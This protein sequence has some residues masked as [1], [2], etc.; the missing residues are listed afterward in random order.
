MRTPQRATL[1][2][3]VVA[4][5]AGIASF[6]AA[7]IYTQERATAIDDAAL[8]IAGNASPSIESLAAARAEMRRLESLILQQ[9]DAPL[10]HDRFSEIAVSRKLLT[11][12]LQRY[13]GLPVFPGEREL[14]KGIRQSVRRF[15]DEIDRAL[16]RMAAKDKSG[17]R[18][19]AHGELRV[20]ADHA[21]DALLLAIEF[22]ARHAQDLALQIEGMRSRSALIAYGLDA[23]SVVLAA[24]AAF[25]A[26][27]TLRRHTNLL[28]SHNRL[29]ERRAEELEAFAG[30]VAHDILSPLTAVAL[31][32]H[33]VE[34]SVHGNDLVAS[35]LAKGQA[36]L[37]RV[38]RMVDGLYE[39]AR[40][41]AGPEPGAHA[42]TTAV[43]QDLHA[44]L[45]PIA[46]E[47]GVEL[48]VEVSY[49]SFVGCS[50]GVLTSILSNLVRNAI[51]Y[52]GNGPTRRVSLRATV[53]DGRARFEVEDS[54]PGIPPDIQPLVFEPYLRAN[55]KQPGI[56]LGLATVKRLVQAHGGTVGVR[57]R[58]GQG[59]LFWCELPIIS[60]AV[61]SSPPAAE[62]PPKAGSV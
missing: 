11:G 62:A 25:L 31:S 59:S 4:F 22:N 27:R 38:T 57:S 28:E 40:A 54:G 50:P 58:V 23:L 39:F 15:D 45:R 49:G 13:L 46:E 61:A 44:E 37:A 19:I 36:S 33:V 17:A 29:L 16:Q 55:S 52:I 8:Q 7:T 10:Q 51:K 48:R 18:A 12:S 24:V 60:T 2:P 21:S 20:A 30:R 6:V 26:V 1:R 43:I 3:L 41:G 56:G 32:M 9:V 5:G 47:K 53:T 34:K 14:W 35:S 42:D